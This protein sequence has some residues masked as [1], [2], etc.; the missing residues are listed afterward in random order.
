MKRTIAAVAIIAGLHL[1]A[2]RA[3]AWYSYQRCPQYEATLVKYT[4]RSGWDVRR[5]SYFAWRESRCTPWV[6]SSTNDHGLL[7]INRINFAYLSARFGVPTWQMASWLKNPTNN[8]RAA[9]SLSNFSYRA[10]GD[11]YRPWRIW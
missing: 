1:P 8:I 4:P 10:W 9:A 5:M 11:R 3:D 7:Q 2:H 6:V